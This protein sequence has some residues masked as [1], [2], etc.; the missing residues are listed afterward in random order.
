NTT[1]MKG[2][3]IIELSHV[4]LPGQEEYCLDVQNRYVEELLPEYY[5]PPDTWYI[6]SEVQLWA[7]VGTHMEAPYHYLKDG[8]DL[9]ALPLSRLAGECVLIDVSDVG[10]GQPVTADLLQARGG[11]I[12]HGDMVFLRSGLSVNYRTPRSHDRPYLTLEAIQ[13]LVDR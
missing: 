3:R 4:L 12:R 1:R 7:H 2:Q 11:D 13:W 9:A 10:I 6:I 5:R 8:A